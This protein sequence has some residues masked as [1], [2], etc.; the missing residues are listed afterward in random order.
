MALQDSDLFVGYRPATEVSYKLKASTFQPAISDGTDEGQLLAWDGDKWVPAAVGT[1]AGELLYWNG[2]NWVPT[3]APTE[4]DQIL[5]WSGT[6]WVASSIID[7]G[8]Y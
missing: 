6:E 7:G 5:E 2:S 1:A 8:I 4:A 3:S